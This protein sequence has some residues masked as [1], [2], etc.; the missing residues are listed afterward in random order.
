MTLS[1]SP[2]LLKSLVPTAGIALLASTLAPVAAAQGS[3]VDPVPARGMVSGMPSGIIVKTAVAPPGTTVHSGILIKAPGDQFQNY[4]ES[5]DSTSAE[6]RPDY[7][8]AAMFPNLT[9][10]QIDA[11]STGNGFLPPLDQNG[12]L[13]LNGN[14]WLAFA[15]SV[16][17]EP[18]TSY[19]LGSVWREAADGARGGD[20]D[21]GSFYF[22]DSQGID[23]TYVGEYFLE[24]PSHLMGLPSST[25]S[26]HDIVA[27]DYGMGAISY[28][29]ANRTSVFFPIEGE[30]Y[31]SVT[32]AWAAAHPTPDFAIDPNASTWVAPHGGDIY[33]LT[34]TFDSFTSQGTWSSPELC[35]TASELGLDPGGSGILAGD[36]D[37]LSVTMQGQR[38][39]FSATKDS[40]F[41]L[42]GDPSQL[43]VYDDAANP[44]V[45]PAKA[46]DGVKL[47]DKIKVTD[48]VPSNS[49]EIDGV[50]D[51]DPEAGH[52][53][54]ALGTS[55]GHYSTIPE[56]PAF[57]SVAANRENGSPASDH[58]VAQV[59]GWGSATPMNCKVV[60]YTKVVEYP[61]G[62]NSPFDFATPFDR[63]TWYTVGV[64][65]RTPSDEDNEFLFR[66]PYSSVSLQSK[67]FAFYAQ[68][69]DMSQQPPAL[70]NETPVSLLYTKE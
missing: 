64:Q 54:A 23:S 30:Y 68:L 61:A 11:H 40:T 56:Q 50:C 9:D 12:R 25:S 34:W 7:S 22:A 1:H 52:V 3:G 6:D 28:N 67:V 59:T 2:F 10:I 48:N 32:R 31:F 63:S 37:A 51:F 36:V 18:A 43:M 49:N 14:N 45:V 62:P 15:A 33:K 24:T 8:M 17:Y 47:T 13:S 44:K 35:K 57:I 39:L 27:L 55:V 29:G 5:W 26:L 41:N 60:L 4:P 69:Y 65:D 19:Q 38:I 58:V 46:A 21:I 66:G 53:G 70:I 42:S 20:S 16:A